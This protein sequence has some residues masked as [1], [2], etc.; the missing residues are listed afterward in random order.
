VRPTLFFKTQPDHGAA[1]FVPIFAMVLPVAGFVHHFLLVTVLFWNREREYGH[2][3]L[4]V[5]GQQERILT[6][7]FLLKA[8]LLGRK[9]TN[10]SST[11]P[12]HKKGYF[13]M[14]GAKRARDDYIETCYI[15]PPQR[16][17]YETIIDA[18]ASS[19]GTF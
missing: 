18:C 4:V 11:W 9:P 8:K 16:K 7:P 12:P 6:R 13:A 5:V 15:L 19:Y 14:V 3:S 10:T 2:C 17:P 1:F